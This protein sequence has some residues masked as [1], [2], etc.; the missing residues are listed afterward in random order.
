[1]EI[2][3][4]DKKLALVE[5]DRAFDTKLPIAVIESLRNKLRF[6]KNAPDERS[7][8]NWK[9]LN[10]EKHENGE[11]SIRL[12]DQYRLMFNIDTESKANRINILRVWDHS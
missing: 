5:T 3:Y 12:N 1:M 10:Y 9:S 2:T 4:D 11:R 6:L 8:R 7:L